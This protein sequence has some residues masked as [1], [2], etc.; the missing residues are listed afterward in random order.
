MYVRVLRNVRE[1]RDTLEPSRKV[2]K[3]IGLVPT[4]GALHAGHETLIQSARKKADVVVVSIFVNP[5]QFGPNEDYG[6]YPRALPNDLEICE[7]SGADVVF[8]PSLE[9]MYLQPQVTFVEVTRVS[10]YLCGAF[11]PGHFRGVATV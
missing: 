7:R 4:M 5:L 10:E 11:R 9:E 3:I 8:A 6:R 1:I 2:N